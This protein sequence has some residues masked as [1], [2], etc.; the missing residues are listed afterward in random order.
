MSRDHGNLVWLVSYPKSG[1]TWL[2]ILLTHLIDA[3]HDTADINALTIGG[4]AASRRLIDALGH[5]PA[6]ELTLEELD[7]LRPAAY[8][9]FADRYTELGFLKVHDAYRHTVHGE[10]IFPAEITRA[11]VYLIRDPLDVAVSFAHHLDTGVD[12][13]IEYMNNNF[14]FA[15]DREK[16][17][18][19]VHQPLLDWSRHVRSWTE[20]TRM[21][22]VVVR[23]EDLHAAPMRSLKRILD[24]VGLFFEDPAIERAIDLS[25][26]KRLQQQETACGFYEKPPTSSP[27]FRTGKVG[28]W[29]RF[30]DAA[31]I[32]KLVRH[33][34]TIM[35]RFGYSIAR[36][37]SP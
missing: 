35:E 15:G 33:H 18:R 6:S 27:F 21:P 25:R 31:Q 36:D 13:V 19:Q 12:D 14:I 30:L 1:N 17:Q 37:V 3:C 32:A 34:G 2:R 29:R 4:D 7:A 10:P 26:F 8:R 16:F 11:V 24:R 9:Q 22:V 20:Q 28:D 23:Y 5:C